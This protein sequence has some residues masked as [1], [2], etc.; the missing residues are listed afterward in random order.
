MIK[1]ISLF[2]F[3]GYL[4]CVYV[5]SASIGVSQGGGISTVCNN[6]KCKTV[7]TQG[8]L[9]LNCKDG[10]CKKEGATQNCVDGKCSYSGDAPDPSYF[11]MPKFKMP[12]FNDFG[13]DYGSDYGMNYDDYGGSDYEM[14]YGN[15]GNFGF[16]MC[17]E[18]HIQMQYTA[19]FSCFKTICINGMWVTK[20]YH[21][22]C[23]E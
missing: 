13:S 21:G 18:G 23:H 22:A 15:F 9:S 11:K 8:H 12:S 19:G 20:Q 10:K 4:H 2:A 17:K 6:G 3:F 1:I 14:G 7:S 16:R 5:N